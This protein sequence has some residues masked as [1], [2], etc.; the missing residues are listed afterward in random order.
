MEKL[1]DSLANVWPKDGLFAHS[2]E[3][4]G[5]GASGR[6]VLSGDRN[7]AK[8]RLD[9]DPAIELLLTVGGDA[10]SP[11][12][13]VQNICLCE[14]WQC[15][16]KA[17]DAAVRFEGAF[18]DGASLAM[19]VTIEGEARKCA[20]DL[21]LAMSGEALESP[22]AAGDGWWLAVRKGP[23]SARRRFGIG[24]SF[25]SEQDAVSQAEKAQQASFDALF[26]KRLAP[27]LSLSAPEGKSSALQ[28]TFCRSASLL[29][30]GA[31]MD[32]FGGDAFRWVGLYRIRPEGS[33]SLPDQMETLCEVPDDLLGGGSA[34]LPAAC[35]SAWRVYEH[36]QSTEALS[37]S[38][39]SLVEGMR[40]WEAQ[41]G[42][43]SGLYGARGTRL[44]GADAVPEAHVSAGLSSLMANEYKC[45]ERMAKS[46]ELRREAE[47]WRDRRAEIAACMNSELW[48]TESLF[49]HDTDDAGEF[50]PVKASA[51]LLPLLGGIPDR[52]QAEAMRMRLMNPTE[53]WTPL[54]VPRVAANDP[55]F[56]QQADA[57]RVSLVLNLLLYHGLTAYGFFQEARELARRSV[58]E[59]VRYYGLHGC[60]YGTFDATTEL[61]PFELLT[62]ESPCEKDVAVGTDSASGAAAFVDLVAELG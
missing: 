27:Y 44:F 38:Y 31:G 33:E 59:A 47:G 2:G 20:S 35:W 29:R 51:G 37:H 41:C 54:P 4:T 8:W 32:G 49:Y 23:P 10:A 24:L 21:T 42:H 5:A 17:N 45:L 61:A 22:V 53:F 60:I 39:A 62:S 7:R 3:D 6:M 16:A 11:L 14:C 52:D 28:R 19:R 36:M 15:R 58:Q 18:V 1:G 30:S 57:R 13:D 12:H 55:L 40:R 48:D 9:A 46:L 26:E 25:Q 34:C 43:G 50:L 56:R